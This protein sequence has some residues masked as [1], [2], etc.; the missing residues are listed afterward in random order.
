MKDHKS[1]SPKDFKVS[2]ARKNATKNTLDEESIRINMQNFNSSNLA[3]DFGKYEYD[4]MHD[5]HYMDPKT[6]MVIYGAYIP[7]FQTLDLIL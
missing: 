7:M 3:E 1:Y 5:G 6:K 4:P 2:W